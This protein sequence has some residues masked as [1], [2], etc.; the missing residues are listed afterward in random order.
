MGIFGSNDI[1]GIFNKD[2]DES[3]AYAIGRAVPSILHAEKIAVGRDSRL[4]SEIIYSAFSRGLM[5][6][7]CDVISIGLCDSPAMYFTV[8]AYKFQ[9]GAMITASHN[10]PEYN[11][12]KLVRSGPAAV[13]YKEGIGELGVIV[14]N[15]L[16][17]TLSLP[18]VQKPGHMSFLDI[19]DDYIRYYRQFMTDIKGLRAVIDC[20]HGTAGV[21]GKKIMNQTGIKHWFLYD[22]PDGSF[23]VHGPDPMDAKNLMP[24]SAAVIEKNADIGMCFDG[25]ADRVVFV[26]EKGEPVSSDLILAV[27]AKYYLSRKPETII[28]DIRCSNGVPE[29]IE[30]HGGVPLM[31][32]VGHVKI[33]QLLKQTGSAFGGELSGHFYYRDFFGCDSAWLTAL[34]VLSVLSR[35]GRTLSE[36][37]Q[38]VEKYAYSG[39]MNFSISRNPEAVFRQLAARYRDGRISYMDGIRVDFPD[40]WFI[41]RSST[42]EPLVRLVVEAKEKHTLK[43]RI[44]EVR[45]L[46]K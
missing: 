44:E 26:N 43:S 45:S 8:G 35:S 17:E 34:M 28:Y 23:P 19:E 24:L 14:E 41:V 15:I 10:P 40:W 46:I 21:F 32:P 7:G 30:K 5:D 6:S 9:G 13:G 11:G 31:S 20:S 22:T 4:S 38:D 42:N 33:K 25:D 37:A 16:S 1:R 2:W 12:I 36:T 3:T 29:Y 39:E 18:Y 27:L